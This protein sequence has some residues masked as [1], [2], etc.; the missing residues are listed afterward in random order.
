MATKNKLLPSRWG[1]AAGASA[2]RRSADDAR[3]LKR[4]LEEGRVVT[5]SPQLIV[6]NVRVRA[7]RRH[8]RAGTPCQCKAKGE[9]MFA[10]L[11]RY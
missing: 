2:P 10:R 6:S 11:V 7:L 9:V 1:E 5:P 3:E 4:R 8:N